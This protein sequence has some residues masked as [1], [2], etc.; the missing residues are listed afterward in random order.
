MIQ[1]DVRK[2]IS[3]MDLAVAEAGYTGRVLSGGLA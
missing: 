3:A 1:I 2:A